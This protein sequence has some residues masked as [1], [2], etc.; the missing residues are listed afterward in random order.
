MMGI[1]GQVLATRTAIPEEE[2]EVG[3]EAEAEARV[4]GVVVGAII[5]AVEAEAE[6][7]RNECTACL[8]LVFV[9]KRNVRGDVHVLVIGCLG[10]VGQ[11]F[12]IG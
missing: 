5:V 3:A 6:A 1:S 4:V 7:R 9:M 8:V 2:E 11:A 10:D 12:G